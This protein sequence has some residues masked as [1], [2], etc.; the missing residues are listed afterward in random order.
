[1]KK[2]IIFKCFYFKKPLVLESITGGGQKISSVIIK[3][4]NQSTVLY[5]DSREIAQKAGIGRKF[6]RENTTKKPSVKQKE[7]QKVCKRKRKY[8]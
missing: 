5:V 7:N 2:F 6:V 8:N 4:T 3:K 1:M